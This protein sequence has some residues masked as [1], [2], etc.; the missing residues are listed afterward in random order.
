MLSCYDLSLGM[1]LLSKTGSVARDLLETPYVDVV[2]VARD[3]LI[4]CS[5]NVVFVEGFGVM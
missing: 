4:I 3:L 1:L 2:M 5:S